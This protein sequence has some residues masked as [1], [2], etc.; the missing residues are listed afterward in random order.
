MRPS[1]LL[2][3]LDAIAHNR[4]HG[5]DA[6]RLF[7]IGS[8]VSANG[9]RRRVAIAWIGR[10]RPE[11]WSET[12]RDVDFFDVRGLV[13]Q[14]CGA[15]D[16]A[17]R[18]ESAAEPI[19]VD[20]RAARVVTDESGT[21]LGIVGQLLPAIVD[22]RD[23][24]GRDEVYLAELDLD[25]L[26]ANADS[27]VRVDPLPRFPSIVRDLS[28]LVSDRLPAADV[29]GT[30][31]SAAPSTLVDLREFDRYQGRGIPEGRVS[32]SYHLTFRA[33]NRTLTD[34]EVDDAME[35]IVRALSAAHRA[36]RR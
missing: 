30:I 31:R 15:F 11:H 23:V 22:A 24:P 17:P 8:V 21:P 20:G 16:V 12:P 18:F 36:E 29:R 13:E 34:P 14:L 35:A 6:A 33:G 7:E 28:I 25:A 1:L 26:G 19:L 27:E 10:T 32:L 9:E 4:R 5:R 2:G 3:L